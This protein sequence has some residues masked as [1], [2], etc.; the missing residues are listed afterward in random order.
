MTPTQAQRLIHDAMAK[1]LVGFGFSGAGDIG[2]FAR[3]TDTAVDI[4]H[5]GGRMA[6]GQVFMFGYNAAIRYSDLAPIVSAAHGD[7]PYY[8]TVTWPHHLL[9]EDREFVEWGLSS[10]TASAD[11][12]MDVLQDIERY[13]LPL[14]AR[15]TD[16][17]ALG[18]GL[19]R[20]DWGSQFIVTPEQRAQRLAAIAA[21]E[22]DIARAVA[23]METAI[24]RERHPG[25][26]RRMQRFIASLEIR[27][28]EA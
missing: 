25:R 24:G 20:D 19:E 3:E 13:A 8:P 23:I 9:H 5:F 18:A 15:L 2:C 10:A 4:L 11:L 7:D 21:T 28:K 16:T 1:A 26:R 12:W 22:G 17:A 27:D 6:A 14:F